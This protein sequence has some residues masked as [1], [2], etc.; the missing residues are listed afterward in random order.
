MTVVSMY[1]HIGIRLVI[2]ILQGSA[3]TQIMLGGL[4]I[5]PSVASYSVY[6]PK[7]TKI[8]WQYTKLVL[9]NYQAY[10]F[11]PTPYM[12]SKHLY[13]ALWSAVE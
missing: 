12:Q 8:G 10:F 3:V 5:Y 4:T 2:Q 1:K 9:K 6:V 11:W 7:I 13:L